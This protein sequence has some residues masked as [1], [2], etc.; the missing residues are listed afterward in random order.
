[1][2]VLV[3]PSHTDTF[4]N[5]VLEALASGVPAIVTG[6]GGPK[7][8]VREGETGF[9]ATDEAFP[10][11]IARLARDRSLLETMRRNAR[12]YALGCSWDAVFEKVYAGYLTALPSAAFIAPHAV[13]ADRA[14]RSL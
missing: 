2:D 5:V 1:M 6:D 8:I 7:F 11:A 4:G 10:S 12:T 13:Q 14:I 3:F 9:I